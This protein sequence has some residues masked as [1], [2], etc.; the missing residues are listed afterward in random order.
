MNITE[1][2][3]DKIELTSS[4]RQRLG[5]PFL[6]IH[7]QTFLSGTGTG[8]SNKVARDVNAAYHATMASSDD[9]KI[10]CAT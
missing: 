5:V 6:E 9:R 4:E 7:A 10:S 1:H 3:Q 2:A 8:L